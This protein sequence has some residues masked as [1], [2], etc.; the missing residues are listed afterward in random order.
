MYL[1]FHYYPYLVP[2]S[3]D[4][5]NETTSLLPPNNNN[6]ATFHNDAMRFPQRVAEL[7]IDLVGSDRN[8]NALDVGC[9]V[10]GSSF[11]LAKHFESVSAF[12]FSN[13]FV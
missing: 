13:S 2:S 1:G 11:A 9:A 4:E 5:N 10:G 3:N 7:L 12:D 8:K 6:N